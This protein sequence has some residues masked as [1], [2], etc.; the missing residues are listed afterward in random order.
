[1]AFINYKST[2]NAQGTLL[3]GISASATAAIL[4]T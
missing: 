1:M 4:A 3:A 2:N